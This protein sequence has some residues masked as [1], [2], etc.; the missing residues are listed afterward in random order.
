[1]NN[2]NDGMAWGLFPIVFA[3]AGM[4]L[5]QVAVLAAIYPATW[6]IGQLVTGA[7]S[8]R[9]GRQPL[10]VA[11]MWIQA[12]GIVIIA[13]ASTFA[14]FAAGS[15]LLGI[16]TAMVY[17]T[18]IAAVGDVAHPSWRAAAVLTIAALTFASETCQQH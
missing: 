16:G 3:A 4:S 8:D 5:R 13:L 1:V 10:I 18:L 11:G 12:V 7:I 17:P 9:S 15:L 2:L 6:S 14:A